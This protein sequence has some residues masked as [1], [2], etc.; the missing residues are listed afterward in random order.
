[1]P[2]VALTDIFTQH[3]GA[4]DSGET[5]APVKKVTETVG[6]DQEPDLPDVRPVQVAFD[7]DDR[8]DI[9]PASASEAEPEKPKSE[10]LSEIRRHIEQSSFDEGD[11]NEP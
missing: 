3:D 9:E 2:E 1:M 11:D 7:Y 4:H 5:F 10:V 6:D 8:D